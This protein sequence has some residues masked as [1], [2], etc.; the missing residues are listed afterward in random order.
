[1]KKHGFLSLYILRNKYACRNIS[2]IV[3][4][5]GTW[6]YWIMELIQ[7]ETFCKSRFVITVMVNYVTEYVVQSHWWWTMWMNMLYDH[8]DGELRDWICCTITLMVNYVTEYIAQSY[9]W[10]TMWMNMLYNHSDGELCD[11]ICC[12]ITLVVN[13]VTEYFVW[14]HWWQNMWLNIVMV[15]M[16][17]CLVQ[18]VMHPISGRFLWGCTVRD[19]VDDHRCKWCKKFSAESMVGKARIS[20]KP[21]ANSSQVGEDVLCV[22][23]IY[24][25]LNYNSS[26]VGED[27]ICVCRIYL[28]LNYN[29]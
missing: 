22:C 4:F 15:A 20:V 27:V 23:R 11:W 24:L 19:S 5:L 16:D 13:Y 7:K 12:A 26:Q 9:W 21:A 1:M 8:T 2:F 17:T 28:E 10:W 25:E 18:C 14:S 3:H 6:F 29:S